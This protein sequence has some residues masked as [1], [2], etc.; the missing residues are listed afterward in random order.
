[1]GSYSLQL[2]H[3]HT[4]HRYLFSRSVCAITT[5]GLLVA[6]DILD[7]EGGNV[8]VS[9]AKVVMKEFLGADRIHR[10]EKLKAI[11]NLIIEGQE[12]SERRQTRQR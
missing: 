11:Y 3:V 10:V 6:L 1:M 9:I 5:L 7:S 2:L 12:R 8:K 4:L